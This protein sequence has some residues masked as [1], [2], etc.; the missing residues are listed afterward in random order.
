MKDK[1]YKI[2]SCINTI[3]I[4][5]LLIAIP[6]SGGSYKQQLINYY[7]YSFLVVDLLGLA[8]VLLKPP[9]INKNVIF[10]FIFLLTYFLPLFS[11][12][13]I[14]FHEHIKMLIYLFLCFFMAINISNSVNKKL[15]NK[16][17]ILSTVITSLISIYYNFSVFPNETFNIHG[18]YGDNYITSIYR[19]YG[20]FLYPNSLALFNL[21][22]IIL[23]FKYIKNNVFKIALYIN[24]LCLFLTISKSIIL[25]L[26][27]VIVILYFANK[28]DLNVVF[29]LVIPI[30]YNVSI[31]RTCVL[32]DSVIYFTITTIVG[33]ILFFILNIVYNKSKKIFFTIFILTF[34][35]S[36]AFIDKP[37]LIKNNNKDLLI[38]DMM[39]TQKGQNTI[40]LEVSGSELK[41]DFFLYK[42]FIRNNYLMF[43]IVKIEPINDKVTITFD[44]EDNAEFYSLKI[45]NLGS[46]I[47]I[48]S[49]TLNEERIN[50]DY[51]LIPF[52][53]IKSF[54]QM[55]YDKSSIGSRFDLYKH[56]ISLI[57]KNPWLGYGY[58][59]FRV[60]ERK[61]NLRTI[62]VEH[63][64]IMTVGVENG[65]IGIIA[66][67]ILLI[68]IGINCIRSFTKDNVYEILVVVLLI[69]SS[70]FDFSLQYN[71]HLLILFVYSMGL[72][73][74]KSTDILYISSDGG[75]LSIVKKVID[76][77]EVSN[78]ALI[79]ENSKLKVNCVLK[80]SRHHILRYILVI[81]INI[82]LN[83][84]YFIHYNPKLIITTGAHTG[85]F[86]C[87]LGKIF[88]R[89]VIYIEVFDRFKTL[90]VS[91]KLVY[92]IADKFIVQHKELLKDYKKAIYI[93]EMY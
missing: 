44:K 22:G 43:D 1:I 81:P 46:D 45:N 48:V 61:G 25:F 23:S 80:E 75:H 88:R 34:L 28:K 74:E 9:K 66:W 32:N 20:T 13:T 11:P 35:S 56:S 2:L 72:L 15:L 41:G 38:V 37:L 10:Y 83:I 6:I 77:V 85:V 47:K 69:Y 76:N 8:L 24:M 27:L 90:T 63:S 18:Y 70:F 51:N 12:R 4:V 39:N 55:K 36:I 40:C 65:I 87:Y 57:K 29:P 31:Y 62:A 30:L 21:I 71:F 49:M 58:D 52:N 93:G 82:F 17:L 79:T 89:K 16:V 78:W 26:I 14:F 3:T 86:M 64:Q 33:I 60:S 42:S 92:K 68:V 54:E 91:G 50:L 67:L 7:F 84:I 5:I 19:L 59:F 53:Y 73:K